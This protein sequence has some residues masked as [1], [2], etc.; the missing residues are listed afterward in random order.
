[1]V[2][3]RKNNMNAEEQKKLKAVMEELRSL[4][5]QYYFITEDIAKYSI[6]LAEDKLEL[7]H[8]NRRFEADAIAAVYRESSVQDKR[9]LE[10]QVK[11]T[12]GDL[13]QCQYRLQEINKELKEQMEG[14]LK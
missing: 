9:K 14:Y 3:L 1:M 12:E 13:A 4:Q 5:D 7:D 6:E 2:D 10:K 8:L 11:Q